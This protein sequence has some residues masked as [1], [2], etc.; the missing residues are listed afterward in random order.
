M[1]FFLTGPPPKTIPVFSRASDVPQTPLRSCLGSDPR[2]ASGFAHRRNPQR[3][4][5]A[6]GPIR[7]YPSSASRGGRPALA[8][9]SVGSGIRG[10]ESE[11]GTPRGGNRGEAPPPS[12]R[13]RIGSGKAGDDA[14]L[15]GI[16]VSARSRDGSWQTG[17]GS[18]RSRRIDGG[19]KTRVRARGRVVDEGRRGEGATERAR[20]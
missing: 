19:A 10:S 18:P 9:G 16:A 8:A 11:I 7:S 1:F 14:V 6:P 13:D 17:S 2:S 4:K 20:A 3:T 5:D 12:I 15:E